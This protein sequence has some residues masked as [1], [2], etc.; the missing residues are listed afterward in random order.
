MSSQSNTL[1]SPIPVGHF[2][3]VRDAYR[4]HCHEVGQASAQRPTLVFLH[5]SGPGASG[6]SNFHLNFPFFAEQGFHVL[7][8]DFLGYGLSDKPEDVQ[9]TSTLHV[10]LLHEVLRK[11]NV[12]RAVLVGNS[13]GG[14]IAFQYGLTYP[15]QIDKL[16]VMGPGGVED[17]ALWAAQ[18][19]GLRCMGAFIAGRKTD[20]ESFREL[21][22]HIVASAPT[23][24][25][26]II[27][28]RLPIWLEQP[29]AVYAT[30][31]V[32]VLTERLGELKMPVLCLWGQKDN[33][34]P[35][36]HALIVAERVPDVR[37]VISG[38]SGHWFML[39]EPDYFNREVLDFLG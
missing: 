21:L 31:K 16:V 1:Q 10:E 5:G 35:V 3:E 15:E 20:R 26:E 8:P 17:P 18:M 38:R 39:E 37:V 33:F 4:L 27:D 29:L 24:T 23:I 19:S 22:H 36:R 9:Y 13:M 7:V 2:I 11:K 25:E 6:Y 28:S 12:T 30:I 14:A 34:L 32:E